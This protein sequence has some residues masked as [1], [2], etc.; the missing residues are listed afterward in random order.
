MDMGIR[1][2]GAL[3]WAKE[4]PETCLVPGRW[5]GVWYEAHLNLAAA[6]L[7]ESRWKHE[8][9]HPP[10]TRC[11]AMLCLAPCETVLQLVIMVSLCGRLHL[12]I[13]YEV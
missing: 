2:S 6:L 1:R 10:R 5:A 12:A 9:G 7:R 11:A 8:A 3:S 13:R 4:C